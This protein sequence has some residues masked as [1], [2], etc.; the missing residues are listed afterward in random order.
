MKKI[1]KFAVFFTGLVLLAAFS[2]HALNVPH[3]HPKFLGEGIVAVS[4]GEDKK[5]L[6]VLAA[7]FAWVAIGELLELIGAEFKPVAAV[8]L[9]NHLSKFF[10]YIFRFLRRGLLE[11]K[12]V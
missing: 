3:K 8:R 2:M 12:P 11:P 7:F 6:G 9:Q 1:Q 10:N 5:L 4:Y